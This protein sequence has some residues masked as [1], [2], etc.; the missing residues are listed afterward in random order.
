VPVGEQY[1]V[2]FGANEPIEMREPEFLRIAVT[3]VDR[4]HG[5]PADKLLA[6]E[7]ELVHAVRA[8]MA[9]RPEKVRDT[10]RHVGMVAAQALSCEVALIRV[11]LDGTPLIEA[12]HP[13][14]AQ[15][16]PI[17]PAGDR[18]LADATMSSA[19]TVDQAT[20]L[21]TGARIFGMEVASRMVLR[22]GSHPAIGAIALGHASARPRGFTSLCQRIGRALAEAAELLITQAAAREELS[23]ER[24]LL[25][26]VS[27]TDPLTG[28]AN[29]RAWDAAAAELLGRPDSVR[30]FVISCDL[31]G[32]KAANDRYG[33]AA[34]DALLRASANLLQ[35]CMRDGDLVSRIGGDEFA[36]LI[37][38]A[39]AAATARVCRG[40][41][42]RCRS[43]DV[44]EQT[45]ANASAIAMIRRR[46]TIS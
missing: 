44:C 20:V 45:A 9:Y 25:A 37:Y 14:A 43:A 21:S 31:D 2:V 42:S 23:A 38:G 19:P 34:G 12:V 29:R 4:I 13:D 7:L 36:V 17:G 39:D 46:P 1:V 8:L 41:P 24:D 6:D 3:A 27:G 18:Y 5:V 26:R 28:L 40:G 32:L 30:A 22:L 33:H 15:S 10:M 35:S 16:A 11:D